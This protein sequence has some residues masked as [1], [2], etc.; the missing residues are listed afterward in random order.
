MSFSRSN[1]PDRDTQRIGPAIKLGVREK[2][3]AA[4]I[5]P[6]EQSRVPP[7]VS[8]CNGRYVFEHG[9]LNRLSQPVE[10]RCPPEVAGSS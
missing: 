7:V 9:A 6:F 2:C 1:V 3:L 4:G 10:E 8:V 5:Q